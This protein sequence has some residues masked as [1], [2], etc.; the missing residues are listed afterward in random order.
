MVAQTDIKYY[1]HT[2][3]KAPQ[4]ENAY[5]SMLNVLDACLVNGFGSQTVDSLTANGTTVTADFGKAHNLLRFQVVKIDGAVQDE[6]NGEHRI[7]DVTANTIT[8]EIATP[9][10]AQRASGL[11]NC[12]LPPL[13][14]EKPFASV[15][16]TGGGKG[17]YRSKNTLLPNRPFLRVVDEL[18]PSYN[19]DWAKFAKVGMVEDMLDI[20]TM[21]GQQ[22]PFDINNTQKNW[23]GNSDGNGWAKWY[24]AL[25]FNENTSGNEQSTVSDGIRSWVIIGNQDWFFI[26]NR[27]HTDVRYNLRHVPMFFGKIEDD[28][29]NGSC[30]VSIPHDNYNTLSPYDMTGISY[31][32]KESIYVSND[33]SLHHNKG[34]LKTNQEFASGRYD[35]VSAP[36]DD[37]PIISSS[38]NIFNKK[39]VYRGYFPSVEFLYQK[40]PYRHLHTFKYKGKF[41]IAVGCMS[42]EDGMLLFDLGE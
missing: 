21:I 10:T 38:I 15:N 24:Y 5:G 40:L 16:P 31:V 3:H 26:L 37:I 14:W 8:F 22:V 30:L 32:E 25:A 7:L 33:L 23:V 41:K 13:G 11:I 6:F 20:D 27:F 36:S 34:Y 29:L 39:N 17:A 12:S 28:Y 35:F 19:A 42:Y 4:L 9:A 1:V 2:N 18:D